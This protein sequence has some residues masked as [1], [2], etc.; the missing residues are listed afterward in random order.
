M[1]ANYGRALIL[2]ITILGALYIVQVVDFKLA[3]LMA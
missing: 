3:K 1:H 2:G